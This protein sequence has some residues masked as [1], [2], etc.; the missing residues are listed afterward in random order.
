MKVDTAS[1]SGIVEKSVFVTTNDPQ[2]EIVKL[3][4]KAEI[5]GGDLSDA[6]IFFGT[7]LGKRSLQRTF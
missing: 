1:L 5:T 3:T 7:R 6:A 2:N 4:I